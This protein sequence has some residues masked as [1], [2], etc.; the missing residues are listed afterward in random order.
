MWQSKPTL[1]VSPLCFTAEITSSSAKNKFVG[2]KDLLR[3][4]IN[5][6]KS[7]LEN[8]TSDYEKQKLEER[9]AKLS[10]GVAIISVGAITEVEMKDKKLRLE[11][12]LAATK[13]AT[14]E[15]VV[16]GGG[17]SY[18]SSIENLEKLISTLSGDEKIGAS[19][20][21]QAIKEPIKQIAKNSGVEG[22]VIINEVLKK[23]DPEFGYDALND[24]FVNMFEAGI[25]DPT[26]VA[27]SAIQN[28]GSVAATLL[29][30]EVLIVDEEEKNIKTQNINPDM[31]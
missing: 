14:Q 7:Q 21:L 8:T 5:L 17:S 16:V 13:A 15:G 2:N 24:R 23:Q 18:L 31:Y 6:I 28:A 9:L 27:R 4:R 22:S 1:I 29:T 10:G 12:A 19:I 30:T 3:N 11:D 25:I 20:V 26:K